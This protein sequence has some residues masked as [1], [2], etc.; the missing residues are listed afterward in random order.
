MYAD[1]I[2]HMPNAPHDDRSVH[3]VLMYIP[4]NANHVITTM[5]LKCIRSPLIFLHR[6]PDIVP[7]L[8]ACINILE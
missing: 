6:C 5:G 2:K 4:T 1:S 8:Q 3:R 7:A